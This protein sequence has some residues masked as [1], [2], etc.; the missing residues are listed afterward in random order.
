MVLHKQIL[1]PK[2]SCHSARR[3]RLV[4]ID[5]KLVNRMRKEVYHHD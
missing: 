4:C 2:F 1:H 3:T 5:K